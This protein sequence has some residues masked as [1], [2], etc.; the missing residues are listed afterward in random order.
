MTMQIRINTT[1]IT[2]TITALTT[3]ASLEEAGALPARPG[4]AGQWRCYYIIICILYNIYYILYI[5]IY[6]ILHI[7]YYIIIL[8]IIHCYYISML[9]II[10]YIIKGIITMYPYIIL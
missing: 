1:M 2:I 9:H 7:I 5:Y 6:I 10:Y 4:L 8:Y 3:V